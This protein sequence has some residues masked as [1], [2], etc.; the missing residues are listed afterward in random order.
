[1]QDLNKFTNEVYATK[2]ELQK[3]LKIN[4]V[5]TFWTKVLAYR[6]SFNLDL[7]LQSIDQNPLSICMC[8]LLNKKIEDVQRKIFKFS[9]QFIKFPNSIIKEEFKVLKLSENLK[10]IS[11]LL[12]VN[13]NDDSL[14]RIVKL[15]L[16]SIDPSYLILQK[17]SLLINDLYKEDST[18]SLDGITNYLYKVCHELLEESISVNNSIFRNKSTRPASYAYGVYEECPP[19]LIPAMM[20]KLFTFLKENRNVSFVL[21][22]AILAYYLQYLKPFDAYGEEIAALLLKYVSLNSD[23]EFPAVLIPF[24]KIVNPYSETLN[25]IIND[26]QKENDLTYYVMYF[27]DLL[28]NELDVLLDEEIKLKGAEIQNDYYRDE[29][30]NSEVN[31]SIA[32]EN[33]YV[34]TD[35]STLKDVDEISNYLNKKKTH[36]DEDALNYTQSIALT[37]LTSGLSEEEANRLEQHLVESNPSLSRNQASFYARHCT[38]GKYYTIAQFKRYAACSYE[39]ARTS[40]DKLVK[41][42]YYAKE[43]FK[44]KFIYTPIK[45]K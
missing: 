4:T 38:L 39:T 41:E 8:P 32:S 7:S 29:S 36:N 44:N 43:P 10:V 19:G 34:D 23:L 15:E 11:N 18:S 9:T 14:K 20:E 45:R 26:V 35:L 30:K 33:N 5:D 6:S 42:G 25:N 16:T 27:L 12:R 28:S 21:K 40:M 1:M 2:Q 24:E 22:L 3:A 37:N 31:G 13:V 17:Y